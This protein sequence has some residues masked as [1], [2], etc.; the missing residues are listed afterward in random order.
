[1]STT[2]RP[3]YTA[4]HCIMPSKATR[5]ERDFFFTGEASRI[6]GVAHRTVD[7][8]ARTKLVVPSVA[9]AKGIGSDRLYNFDDLVALRVARELRL[10]GIS[11]QKLRKV[12]RYLRDRGWKKPLAQCKLVMIGDDLHL[13]Q[14]SR[15]MESLFSKP[16]QGVFAFMLDLNRA[17]QEV[18]KEV[19]ALL[20]A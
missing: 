12:V 10:A 2:S 1:M 18:K 8:W 5:K 11:T 15:E 9:D 6:T 14:T 7:Y 17:V 16:G 4:A 13:V 19:R 20:A 3:D